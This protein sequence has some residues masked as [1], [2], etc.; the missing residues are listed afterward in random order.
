VWVVLCL[1]ENSAVNKKNIIEYLAREIISGT[2]EHN[3]TIPNEI[4]FAANFGVSRTMI[5]DVLK[6]LEM[7]GLIERRTNVG[8][9]VRS[10]NSWNLLDPELIGWSSGLLT[11]SRFLLSLMELRLII[12]P[13]AAAL[14]AIRA[15]DKNLIQIRGNFS[16]MLEYEP[17]STSATLNTE[18]D[19]DFHKSILKACGNLF[20]S[21]FGSAIQGALHHTIYLSNK[22]HLDHEA[23]HGC[24]QRV[25]LAIENRDPEGAYRGMCTVLNN[26]ISDLE[27]QVSGVILSDFDRN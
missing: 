27:L 26:A 14:A 17:H 24:H 20:L 15:S 5:R 4:D 13:Q 6:S 10:I 25:L 8:T 16:R 22:I 2:L 1:P 7:K 3:E 23:S 9:R 18:A 11:D 19:I 12:E 21:Q